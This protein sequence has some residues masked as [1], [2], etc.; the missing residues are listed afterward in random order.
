ML[1]SPRKT[2]QQDYFEAVDNADIVLTGKQ[3][4]GKK[5]TFNESIENWK[6]KKNISFQPATLFDS[7]ICDEVEVSF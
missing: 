5:Q 6:K 7:N 1:I 2:K 4:W 3:V